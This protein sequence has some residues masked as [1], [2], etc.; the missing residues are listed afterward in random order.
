MTLARAAATD[1]VGTATLPL[2]ELEELLEEV[3]PALHDHIVRASLALHTLSS[4]RA[5]VHAWQWDY[6]AVGPADID[7]WAARCASTR[8]ACA[9]YDCETLKQAALGLSPYAA[10]D[11]VL[12]TLV[13]QLLPVL[14]DL[15]SQLDLYGARLAVA[16]FYSVL[17]ELLDHLQTTP[18]L[19]S[20]RL[21]VYSAGQLLDIIIAVSL[22]PIPEAWIDRVAAAEDMVRRELALDLA[23][24]AAAR[25]AADRAALADAA[26]RAD[27]ERRARGGDGARDARDTPAKP[28]PESDDAAAV[29][30]PP[31]TP[32]APAREFRTPENVPGRERRRSRVLGDDADC[33]A[34]PS[35]S[36]VDSSPGRKLVSPLGT[37]ENTDLGIAIETQRIDT[38]LNGSD[39][40]RR[41]YYNPS[42]ESTPSD[43]EEIDWESV[44]DES[45]SAALKRRLLAA[46]G[47]VPPPTDAEESKR[48]LDIAAARD[49]L[50]HKADDGTVQRNT[51][52]RTL[53][54]KIKHILDAL[55]GSIK[56]EPSDS[57][58]QNRM[59]ALLTTSTSSALSSAG[60]GQTRK[61]YLYK[62]N[63][64]PQTLWVRIVAERV[65]VRVGGGWTDLAEWLRNYALHHA[66]A[67]DVELF[68]TEQ[69]PAP[70]TRPRS[71]GNDPREFKDPAGRVRR[72]S[73]RAE[74]K[75]TKDLS[76]SLIPRPVSREPSLDRSPAFDDMRSS[77]LRLS[78]ATP[79]PTPHT[80]SA[81][82]RSLNSRDQVWVQRILDKVTPPGE[83]EL[84]PGDVPRALFVSKNPAE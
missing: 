78:E 56:L 66:D 5:D 38:L 44:D 34:S 62:P 13:F 14:G 61:Y 50:Q 30:T 10:A 48:V 83:P 53:D 36:S 17:A 55:P 25:A 28:E 18:A 2:I 33:E 12:L 59:P 23:R 73:A 65:M 6:A 7:G 29:L 15:E 21:L 24:D 32:A 82:H 42:P 41:M 27:A 8:T 4:L 69:P 80:V 26:R 72:A 71:L 49:E 81:K 40:I 45:P 20:R 35:A 79:S 76:P 74:P 75:D 68:D 16:R 77:S 1:L 58:K 60:Y 9:K 31:A 19:L 46:S 52:H 22:E 54:L 67:A 37:I 63:A 11:A 84:S 57:P 3:P 64:P 47:V 43:R 39:I 70:R 51:I